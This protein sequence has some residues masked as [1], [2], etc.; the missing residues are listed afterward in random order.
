MREPDLMTQLGLRADRLAA[1]GAATSAMNYSANFT[2][3]HSLLEQIER[4]SERL[5][6]ADPDRTRE[7]TIELLELAVQASPNQ[8]FLYLMLAY[9][10]ATY[11]K[12]YR[13]G[14][15]RLA[16]AAGLPE[17]PVFLGSLAHQML[18]F[19]RVDSE[20]EVLVAAPE[21]SPL[22][23]EIA[24][25]ERLRRQRV[26]SPSSEL[27]EPSRTLGAAGVRRTRG[28]ARRCGSK[29][30]FSM[31]HCPFHDGREAGASDIALEYN[32]LAEDQVQDPF[33]MYARARGEKPVFFSPMYQMWF[34]TRYEDVVRVLKDTDTFSSIGIITVN[35]DQMPPEVVAELDKGRPQVPGMTDNDPPDHDRIRSL[36]GKAFSQRIVTAMEP[37][38]RS[39]ADSMLDQFIDDGETDILESFAFT[40]PLIVI[41]DVLGVDREHLSDLKQWSDD[42]VA[43][44]AAPLTLEEQLECARGFAAFQNFYY[45]LIE[46]KR[47]SPQQ[48]LISHMIHARLEGREPL[49]TLEMVNVCMSATWAGHQTATSMICSMLYRLL[50]NPE[51][52]RAC[53]EDRSLVAKAVEET[54]RLDSPLLGMLRFTTRDVELGRR[55]DSGGLAGAGALC[56]CQP[57]RTGVRESG[58]LRLAPSRPDE[59][60]PRLWQGACI[61][62][63]DRNWPVWRAR[64]PPRC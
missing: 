33:S 59:P 14:G 30:R 35:R 53:V 63:S 46:E 9:Y 27:H 21:G 19:A 18:R 51:L 26:A 56:L 48:D 29:R 49:T 8:W 6:S 36:V 32:P 25:A 3:L 13:A 34:V 16:A 44:L 50:S 2:V 52:W 38:I 37:H 5:E 45:D 15:E 55:R 4:V 23:V 11:R 42:W 20:L 60:P 31:S 28:R 7:A 1:L 10:D 40:F 24:E 22:Q 41:A 64:L 12:D 62:V 43:L 54:L 47:K 61:T 39:I 58:N 17:A 57:R